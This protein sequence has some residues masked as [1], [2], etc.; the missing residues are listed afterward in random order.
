MRKIG[1]FLI[2]I[3]AVAVLLYGAFDE[4]S[5]LRGRYWAVL[6]AIFFLPIFLYGTMLYEMAKIRQEKRVSWRRAFGI[7]NSSQSSR[8]NKHEDS[9]KHSR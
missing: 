5:F 2:G 3:G 4:D 9:V 8:R 1:Y 7:V 6:T